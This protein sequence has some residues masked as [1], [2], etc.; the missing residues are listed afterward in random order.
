LSENLRAHHRPLDPYDQVDGRST[1]KRRAVYA[2]A[3]LLVIAA[4]AGIYL[5]QDRAE[6]ESLLLQRLS[7]TA[8]PPQVAL[9]APPPAQTEPEVIH[10]IPQTGLESGVQRKPVPPLEES[11]GV[12]RDSLKELL[13]KQRLAGLFIPKDFVH[14]VVSTVD[15]LPRKT[16]ASRLL[17]VKVPAGQI[18]TSADGEAVSLSPANYARY[19]TYVDAARATD[20]KQLVAMYVHFY[21]LFQQAYQE[22][23]YPKKQ[24]NDRLV[25]AIDDLLEAPEVQPPV[26]LVRPK[27]M[28]EFDD[29]ELED[30]SA[31][32]KL[33]VRMGPENAAVL[34]AKLR[35][36]RRE[37]V[38][39]AQT[40]TKK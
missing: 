22:L 33:L 8:E 7:Q 34:K 26:K 12:M 5:W 30:L 15:N 36:I 4:G 31:G 39:E 40:T 14:H 17:P 6:R 18:A 32:Q 1:W 11:D 29:P 20:S 3:L 24:F 25:E 13:N 38:A 10:P 16:V 27:V 37:L 21:P 19:K 23:G 9:P 2:T 35:E 28:Y